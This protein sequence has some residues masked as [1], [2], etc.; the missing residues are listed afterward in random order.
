MVPRVDVDATAA[1]KQTH[2]RGVDDAEVEA[3]LVPHLLLPLHLERRRAD[4]QNLPGAVPDDEFEGHHPRLDGLAQAHVVGDQKVDPWHLDRPH[5]GIKLV[6]FDVDA[7]AK[8]RLDVPHVRRGGC[9]PA[10]GIEKS[11]ES[12]G[13]IKAGRFGQGDLFDDPGTGLELPDDLDFFAQP[14]I[15]DG[16]Q[17][18]EGL[19]VGD[20]MQTAGR[21][22]ARYDFVDDPVA[23][24]NADQLPLLRGAGKCRRHALVP[25]RNRTWQ[26]ESSLCCKSTSTILNDVIRPHKHVPKATSAIRRRVRELRKAKAPQIECSGARSAFRSRTT[27]RPRTKVE[28]GDYPSEKLLRKPA[29][30]LDA[31]PDELFLLAQI[32][33]S[34]IRERV[35]ARHDTFLKL[36]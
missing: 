16:C 6:V 29:N 15:F 33:P 10:D 36:G 28:F 12:V 21:Q 7:G 4:D 30:A 25:R 27:R 2:H 34:R 26:H 5:D 3:E 8:R 23:G 14:V 9:P 32:V 19:R 11:V 35:L 22:R 31:D 1:A 24:P 20:P 18:D 13:W 17:R